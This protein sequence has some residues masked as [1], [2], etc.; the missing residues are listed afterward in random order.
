MAVAKKLTVN[1]SPTICANSAV[2]SAAQT[3]L[4]QNE[5]STGRP[6][7]TLG[8]FA[9]RAD[10]AIERPRSKLSPIDDLLPCPTLRITTYI[11]YPRPP[12]FRHRSSGHSR[13]SSR[14]RKR[15]PTNPA[16]GSSSANGRF[17]R[18][19]PVAAHSGDRLLSEPT[20][21]TQPSPR[22]PLF[23]PDSRPRQG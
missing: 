10:I 21:A 20:T 8:T 18:I 4:T 22:E 12:P 16:V 14:H 9:V 5:Y 7:C 1:E 23:M 2:P 6:L 19:S 11:L 3:S 15:Y 17:R 13:K